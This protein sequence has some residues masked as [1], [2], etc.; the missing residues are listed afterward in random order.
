MAMHSIRTFSGKLV[1]LRAPKLEDICIK[2]IAHALARINRFTGHTS[3]GYTVA[4]HS[5]LVSRFVPV[6]FALDG[7]LH[8]ASEAYLGDV[9]SP[10]KSLLPEY[11]VLEARWTRVIE[12]KFGLR[13]M[14][15]PVK[16][17]DALA[18]E[19]EGL[20]FVRGW[21]REIVEASRTSMQL[22]V[23]CSMRECLPGRVVRSF[24]EPFLRRFYE[25]MYVRANPGSSEGVKA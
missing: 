14:P 15:A 2:D 22:Q 19:A 8:D 4:E 9:A 24:E 1:D 12:A 10:L 16:R 25:L 7:L 3:R 21:D 5:L 20:E 11:K 13:E 23:I 18:L 6:E 17:A